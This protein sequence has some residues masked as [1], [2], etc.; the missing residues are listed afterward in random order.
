MKR[1]QIQLFG[2][3]REAEPHACIAFDTQASTIAQLRAELQSH[4]Q[5]W[6]DAA[7]ALLARSAFASAISVLRDAEPLPDDGQLALLPPVS[8]G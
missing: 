4:V 3:L 8:G 5:A 6:P 1:V 2:A 7:R